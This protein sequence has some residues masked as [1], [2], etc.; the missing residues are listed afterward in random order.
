MNATEPRRLLCV[1]AHPDDESYGPGGTI[2]RYALEGVEVSILMFT[3]GEAGSIG[4][5]KELPSDELCRRRTR[6]FAAACDALGVRHHRILG[7][8]DKG[9]GEAD[10]H[11]AVDRILEAF[12]AYR[13][14]VV[15]TFHRDGVS[16]HPDHIAVTRLV[17]TAFDRAAQRGGGPARLYEWGIPGEKA[18]LYERPG[19]RVMPEHEM[20]ACITPTGEA[21]DRK[22]RAIRC[23]ATQI[24]F[25]KSMQSRF[26]YRT[27]ASPEWFTRRRPAAVPGGA[28]ETDL[29]GAFG[30]PT[31]PAD[32]QEGP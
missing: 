17:E 24:D 3:C 15:I 25:F 31:R 6:E 1:F 26:D 29:F 8:P 2:A 7:V 10:P 16:G 28:V 4:V 27:E 21:M 9:V 12:D 13:P 18:R 14:G 32:A 19:L 22:L 23:H 11:W 5:S 30:S 20:H